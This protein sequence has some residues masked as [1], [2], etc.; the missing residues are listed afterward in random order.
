MPGPEVSELAELT[1]YGYSV[2]CIVGWTLGAA[3]ALVPASFLVLYW[4]STRRAK[5]EAL[6][7]VRT[8]ALVCLRS[9]FCI[10]SSW[11]S[12]VLLPLAYCF[13][14]TV[15][16]YAPESQY[17]D[18]FLEHFYE[19]TASVYAI[20]SAIWLSRLYSY[21][22]ISKGKSNSQRP[23]PKVRLLTLLACLVAVGA[24]KIMPVMYSAFFVVYA[25]VAIRA[26]LCLALLFTNMC[27][28]LKASGDSF[29]F[30]QGRFWEMAR[31]F[32]FAGFLSYLTHL[33]LECFQGL[34]LAKSITEPIICELFGVIAES[35][36]ALVWV[37]FDS[38]ILLRGLEYLAVLEEPSIVVK[39]ES[40]E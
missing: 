2:G 26:D 3:I 17:N 27:G 25:L 4:Q 20:F 30:A 37:H 16:W 40:L 36:A 35:L 18:W 8:D 5:R 15:A 24:N 21:W 38:L 10:W 6:K 12:L 22:Y 13:L 7:Q 28:L 31:L 19:I 34:D 9:Y 32:S 39:Q 14:W 11:A 33:G 1:D 23:A 29:N